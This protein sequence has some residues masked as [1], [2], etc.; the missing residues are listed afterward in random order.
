MTSERKKQ[1]EA[2]PLAWLIVF[3][4]LVSVVPA[5]AASFD[6]AK[7]ATKV[8]K[9]ICD[10][11]TISELDD[12]LGKAYRDA[13]NKDHEEQK[14]RLVAEQEHWLKHVRNLC[15]DEPCFKQAYSSR[16]AALAIFFKPKL[17]AQGGNW[18]YRGNSGRNE[19]L[20][21][22]LLR[23]LNRY[24]RD[25]SLDNRC[26]F[27]VI[28]SY[29]SFTAPPWEELDLQKYGELFFK[30]M[31]YSGEDPVGYFQ[32]APGLQQRAPDSHYQYLTQRFIERGGRLRVWRTRLV[33]HYGTGPIIPAPPGEQ[34]IVQMYIPMPKES[35]ATYC[36]GKPKPASVKEVELLFI[37]TP[38]LSGPDPNIDRGTFGILGGRDLMVYEGRPVLVGG[39]DVWRD[40]KLML[41]RLCSF[42]FVQGKK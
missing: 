35:Q 7:A 25:E 4:S 11:P 14:H 42:E 12:D 23:R 20:C 16:L 28:A 41:D 18:T 3:A 22:D 2:D 1:C 29:P 24:D 6:C 26:S 37:V 17:P 40:G 5:Y 31:K 34:A 9:W 32:L 27:P 39:E 30:L 21:H 8:E 19:S 13:I 10:N 33:N 15:S 36:V 38:D